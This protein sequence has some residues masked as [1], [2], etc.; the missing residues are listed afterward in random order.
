MS[1][2]RAGLV[3]DWSWK[4]RKDCGDPME[5]HKKTVPRQQLTYH[6]LQTILDTE[7]S[8]NSL[9]P[10]MQLPLQAYDH[11]NNSTKSEIKRNS[12]ITT[13]YKQITTGCYTIPNIL[14]C[15]M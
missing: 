10:E 13:N 4:E 15:V 1:C 8:W 6:I 11:A 7:T 14:C 5:R 2:S 9:W 12:H 3:L